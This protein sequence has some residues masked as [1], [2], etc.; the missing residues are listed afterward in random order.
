MAQAVILTRVSGHDAL[1]EARQGLDDALTAPA[2]S[3]NWGESVLACLTLLRDVLGRHERASE[4]PG[5]TLDQAVAERPSLAHRARTLRLEHPMLIGDA[6]AI[7][8]DLRAAIAVAN[9]D[10]ERIRW[11]AGAL[12]DAVRRHMAQG[13]DLLYEAFHREDGGEG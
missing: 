7:M 3:T 9:V 6:R 2:D 4:A 5:G 8:A 10:A 1:R 13:T 12:Q 11:K